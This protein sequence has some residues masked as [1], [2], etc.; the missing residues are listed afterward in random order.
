MAVYGVDLRTGN[1]HNGL[2]GFS[3]WSPT[4]GLGQ[5]IYGGGNTN[6]GIGFNGQSQSDHR[7][8]QA[9][10]KSGYAIK[11][12]KT[13]FSNQI[14]NVA[15]TGSGQITYK[16]VLATNGDVPRSA[17]LVETFLQPNRA[18]TANDVNAFR[19]IIN[20][21]TAPATYPKDL[22]GAGGGGKVRY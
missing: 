2:V 3:G 20:R 17:N 19:G 4:L 18:T 9:F 13:V 8:A 12:F 21:V 14:G 6:G 15:G 10:R 16:R 1:A 7:I 22:S 5:P 11:L